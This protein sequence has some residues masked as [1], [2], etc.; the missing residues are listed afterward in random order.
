MTSQIG[1]VIGKTE[2]LVRYESSPG[3]PQSS[4]CKWARNVK[5]TRTLWNYWDS[6]EF[7]SYQHEIFR[8]KIIIKRKDISNFRINSFINLFSLLLSLH[9]WLLI[10]LTWFGQIQHFIANFSCEI[11][12]CSSSRQI[13][14][15]KDPSFNIFQAYHNRFICKMTDIYIYNYTL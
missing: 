12:K 10:G 14:I 9:C 11:K 3:F 4:I 5:N 15:V 6:L 1:T 7:W 2:N 8:K 13:Q